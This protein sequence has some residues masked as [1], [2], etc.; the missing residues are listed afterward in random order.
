M[1]VSRCGWLLVCIAT[2]GALLTSGC[3]PIGNT[4]L[5][6]YH[7]LFIGNSFTDFNGGLDQ[8]LHGLA[9]GTTAERVA[10]G[11]YTLARHLTDETTMGRLRAG[12]WTY[13]VIQEQSQYPVIAA[14]QYLTALRELVDQVR[15]AGAIPLLLVT[16]ARPDD[17]RVTTAALRA[18][19]TAAGQAVK[20]SVIP[21]GP[22]FAASQAAHPEVKL[23]QDDGHPTVEGTY[24]AGCVVYAEIFGTSPEGNTFTDGVDATVAHALQATAEAAARS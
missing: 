23:N 7:V 20:A 13:V 11:G 24:L 14:G 10:P 3:T 8:V 15:A 16:W 2:I 18:A 9:P 21:A 1:R 12:G 22:A 19:V 4:D 17:P 6:R 5:P